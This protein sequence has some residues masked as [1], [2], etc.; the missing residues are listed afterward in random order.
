MEPHLRFLGGRRIGG[1]IIAFTGPDRRDAYG[2]YWTRDTDLALQ[3]YSQRPLYYQ[4]NGAMVEAGLI[5]ADDLVV[6]DDGL[7]M[8]CDCLDNE[9]GEA[10]LDLIKRGRGHYSTGVMPGSWRER[11]DGWIEFWPFVECSITD[12]PATKA[13]LTRASI[14]RSLDGVAFYPNG[15]RVGD[16]EF[17]RRGPIMPPEA[18]EQPGGNGAA[19]AAPAAPAASAPV[20]DVVAEMRQL[21]SE[22]RQIAEDMR[23]APARSLPAAQLPEALR[24]P[25]PVSPN[26]TVGHRFDDMTLAAMALR[27]Q[28]MLMNRRLSG[29]AR[30]EFF[31]ALIDKTER[32]RKR[33][34]LVT[35]D[36]LMRGAVR[37]VD[38]QVVETFGRHIRADEAMTSVY[39]NYGDELVPTLLSSVVWYHM[40]LEAKV[41]N[42]LRRF[43]MPSQPFDYPK[44][45]SGPTFRK[46]AELEDQAN[47][48]VHASVIPSSKIGTDKVTFSA[49][50]I[51]A[52]VLGSN[53]L[54]ED[55]AINMMN[56]WSTQVMRQAA[57]AIDY[58]LLNGDEAATVANISHIGTDPTGTAYDKILVLNGLRKIA[59]GNSDTA[60]Q[61]SISVD[62]PLALRELMGTRGIFGIYPRDLV[63]VAD[64][65]VYY[66]V[67]ALDTFESLAD[68]GPQA[69]L[70]TGMVGAIKGVP[71]I[72]ADELE[73]TNASG[74]I[75]DSHDS[76]L[77]SYLVVNT[78]NLMVGYR[79]PVEMETF[80]VPGADGW[81]LDVTVR[82][83]V[84]EMEAGQVAYG[85]NV[86]GA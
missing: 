42:A 81:A 63:I 13:G 31:R 7:Y 12:R 11:A 46:V 4:H 32:Q 18:I 76:T 73:A 59:V 34:E 21:V 74:Q 25:A 30:T 50:K 44:I 67:V 54:F 39:A 10:C 1:I 84:Q 71:I 52:L 5:Q 22:A 33:D 79:R 14:I 56:V 77:G 17:L 70:L 20:N 2:N 86:G 15:K 36:Q 8:E 65:A 53:E 61:T 27:G 80:K 43:E 23:S 9:A 24:P 85:Y 83:D 57:S 16:D 19:A 28:L 26:I 35:D 41:L 29:E 58:V 40:M 82:L 55:S 38:A 62:S 64:P 45:T 51:G 47:F 49:G 72:V 60:S 68:M 69:T 48:S 75:E 78:A 66:D 6:R 37:M 3:R